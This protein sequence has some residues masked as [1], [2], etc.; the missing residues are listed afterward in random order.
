[1]KFIYL[2]LQIILLW[3]IINNLKKLCLIYIIENFFLIY[4]YINIL[5]LLN[6]IIIGD[7]KKY[8]NCYEIN[9]K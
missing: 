6:Y 3:Y 1:M 9:K 7:V 2:I 5:S 4:Y 8:L